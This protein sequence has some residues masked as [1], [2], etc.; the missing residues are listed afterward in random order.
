M[1]VSPSPTSTSALFAVTPCTTP[2]V[3]PSP[4]HPSQPSQPSHHL[5][6]S[7]WKHAASRTALE[8]ARHVWTVAVPSSSYGRGGAGRDSVGP[9]P[10]ARHRRR[11]EARLP[12]GSRRRPVRPAAA[13]A[14]S[15]FQNTAGLGTTELPAARAL[16]GFVERRPASVNGGGV[17][18]YKCNR[19]SLERAQ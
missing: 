13:P 5:C 14:S 10:S 1:A 17:S 16:S 3:T 18:M 6:D 12:P 11:P 8:P 15:L 7:L 4:S 19:A 2:P 9:T